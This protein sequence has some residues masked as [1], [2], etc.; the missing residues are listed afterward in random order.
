MCVCVC[1]CVCVCLQDMLVGLVCEAVASSLGQDKGLL[2]A[3]FPRNLSQAQAYQARV[4]VTHTHMHAHTH[5]HT[6]THKDDKQY[7][8]AFPTHRNLMQMSFN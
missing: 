2:L 7:D 8:I 6:H 4:R 5:A 3:G 1:V